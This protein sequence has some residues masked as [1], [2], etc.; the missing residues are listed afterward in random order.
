LYDKLSFDTT[1]IDEGIIQL[2]KHLCNKNFRVKNTIWYP[3]L[4]NSF[5]A[6]MYK[7]DTNNIFSYDNSVVKAFFDITKGRNI[8]FNDMYM[9]A[10]L[11]KLEKPVKSK[12]TPKP[13]KSKAT[14]IPIQTTPKVLTKEDF[15]IRIKGIE[16][17]LKYA[18]D[19]IEIKNFNTQLTALKIMLKYS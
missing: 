18:T 7:D 11:Y 6:I 12:K 4:N 17:M 19:P 8:W 14:D 16:I 3:K 9:I 10:D 15:E 13:K 2:D 5:I 1:F